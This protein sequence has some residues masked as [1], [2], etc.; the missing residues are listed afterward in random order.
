M[1]WIRTIPVSQGDEKLRQA[2]EGQKSLYPKEYAT[3]VHPTEG[4][5]AMITESHSLIPEAL[6]HAFSTFGALDVARPAAL[7]R[8]H[9]MI[10]TMVFAHQQV[11]LLN[12]LARRVSASGHPGRRPR[13]GAARGLHDRSDHRGRAGH[14]RLRRQADQG[15]H[16]GIS[17]GRSRASLEAVGFDDQATL[18]SR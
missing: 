11:P 4:G 18:R 15:R 10:A 14:D 9:E 16:E 3:P 1:T 7:R 13:P 5:G 17:P 6:Y 2:M 8:Q 12:C